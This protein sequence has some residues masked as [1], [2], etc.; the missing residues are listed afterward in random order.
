[1]VATAPDASA[2]GVPGKFTLYRG[3]G[4]T[5][6]ALTVIYTLG[7]NAHNGVDYQ[8]LPGTVTF[9]AGA[10]S[11]DVVVQPTG[12]PEPNDQPVII[13]LFGYTGAPYIV[14]KPDSA[15]VTIA[16]NNQPSPRPTV[17]VT[18]TNPNASASGNPGVFT[19][20]RNGGDNS[21]A[22]TVKYTLGGNAHN[23]V[24][25]QTLS[26]LAAIPAGAS[27]VDVVVQPTGQPEPNDQPVIIML[28]GYTG[29]PYIVG[30]PDSAIVTIANP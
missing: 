29:A 25:Y 2:S 10:A 8:T 15:T 24:D 19:I 26:G 14:G 17:T 20:T 28:Y 11:V 22:V 6:S 30:K 4:D 3:D 5:S 23:G 27:S 13:M 12:Q 21:S 16:Y 7:G 1:V 9:P 18:A